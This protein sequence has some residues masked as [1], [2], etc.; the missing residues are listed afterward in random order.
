MKL[1][2]EAREGTLIRCL[3]VL[4]C[5]LSSA[6]S[7]ETDISALGAATSSSFI[8]LCRDYSMP[9]GTAA[10]RNGG[11]PVMGCRTGLY[12]RSNPYRIDD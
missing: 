8:R 10:F 12:C 9:T 5:I 7:R 6:N 11:I 1:C 2:I 3:R 4:H